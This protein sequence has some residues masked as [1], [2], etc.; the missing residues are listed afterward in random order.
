MIKE[1][2]KIGRGATAICICDNCGEV[3]K[4]HYSNI[5]KYKSN[6]CNAECQQQYANKQ[7]EVHCATCGKP[8]KVAH[9]Q[10]LAYQKFYCNNKCRGGDTE[11]INKWVSASPNSKVNKILMACGY[12][13][14]EKLV[15]PWRA[16]LNKNYYCNV[17]CSTAWRA[18]KFKGLCGSDN[19]GWKGGKVTNT[20]GYILIFSPSH[21]S[22]Y[23]SNYVLEHRLI[24]EKAIGRY[25][26]DWEIVHHIN[27][28]KTDNRIENLKLLPGLEHNTKVQE[29]YQE[30][31]KLKERINYLESLTV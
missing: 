3:F 10:I 24:M 30:N 11:A 23:K 14:K 18:E 28:I 27:G 31:E 17:K 15:A 7:V 4:R 1:I 26:F 29:V 25:L 12:C 16:K 6:C 2:I 20:A 22:R 8:K 9:Y 13:G 21:P 19:L 5:A